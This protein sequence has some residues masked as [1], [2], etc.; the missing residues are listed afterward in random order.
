[1]KVQAKSNAK[2]RADKAANE[3]IVQELNRKSTNPE[4]VKKCS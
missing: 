1:M 4:T 3:K 2:L